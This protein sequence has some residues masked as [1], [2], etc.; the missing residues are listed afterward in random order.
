[1]GY[2]AWICG[3]GLAY[4]IVVIFAYVTRGMEGII[5]VIVIAIPFVGYY[6]V[7]T[8]IQQQLR[9]EAERRNR[10]DRLDC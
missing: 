9:N 6:L 8:S 3:T 1:M 5:A 7:G 10:I 4:A 2:F